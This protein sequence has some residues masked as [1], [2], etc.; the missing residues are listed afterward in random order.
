MET[1]IA[2]DQWLFGVI[3]GHWHADFL[4]AIMPFWREK[5]TWIPLYLVFLILG[6]RYWGKRCLGFGLGVLLCVTLA[7]TVSSKIIKPTFK[8]D[9]PC[10][11]LTLQTEARVLIPCGG[12]YSFTS[13]HATN[14]FAIAIFV[15][16]T[17]GVRSKWFRIPILLWAASIAWGQVYVGVHYPL[18]IL[19]GAFLGSCIGYMVVLAFRRFPFAREI[20]A[21]E[22]DVE[23]V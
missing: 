5:S 12:G 1:L 3:N 7:D 22:L 8:R 20:F 16:F 23:S 10:R 9:R 2:W 4:D 18:D 11:E 17:L 14:H 21:P 19:A 6:I 15:W 13:S